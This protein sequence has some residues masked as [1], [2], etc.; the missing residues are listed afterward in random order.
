MMRVPNSD[1]H[2]SA[3]RIFD[4]AGFIQN[5]GIELVQCESGVCITRIVIRPDHYQQ[6][7]VIHAGVVFTLADHAAGAAA[8]TLIAADEIVLTASFNLHLLKGATASMLH[9]RA[10]VLRAGKR[11]LVVE[12]EVFDPATPAIL[13][14]KGTSSL[15]VLKSRTETK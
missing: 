5:L 11:S 10:K 12:A 14:A 3:K 6:D 9:S 4:E 8:T 7:G 2:A 1:F 15:A 13:I